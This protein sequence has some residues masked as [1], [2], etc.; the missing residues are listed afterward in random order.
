MFDITGCILIVA[1]VA[2]ISF[3][4]AQ[5]DDDDQS[6]KIDSK[7]LTFAVLSAISVGLIFSLNSFNLNYILKDLKFNPD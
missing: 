2:L 3:G 4:A 6:E 1:C 5:N 7:Y